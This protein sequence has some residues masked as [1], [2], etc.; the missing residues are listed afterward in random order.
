MLAVCLRGLF[1]PG[2]L[3]VCVVVCCQAFSAMEQLRTHCAT[4]ISL[5]EKS[6][7]S[8]QEL[9]ATLNQSYPELVQ[10]TSQK[11]NSSIIVFKVICECH[12]FFFL[13]LLMQVVLNKAY[14]ATLDSASDLL[15]ETMDEQSALM[16]EVRSY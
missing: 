14:N 12:F 6:V 5:L 3:N 13:S 8:Q 1:V 11:I 15:S 7:G 2:V 9:L 10:I 4:E 16:K